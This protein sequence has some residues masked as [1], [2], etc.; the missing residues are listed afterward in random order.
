MAKA[1]ITPITAGAETMAPAATP[2]AAWRRATTDGELYRLPGSGHVARLR[3]PSLYQLAARGAVDSGLAAQVLKRLTAGERPGERSEADRAQTH[4]ENVDL[5]LGVA[6]LCLVE[7]RLILDRPADPER[8]EI[9]PEDMA[10]A[11]L[12]WLYYDFAQEGD[13]SV[14]TFRVSGGDGAA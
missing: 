7:P 14:A 5:F 12:L 2:A 3:R 4:R 8:G 13:R 6:A 9:G 11:D 1:T 10:D